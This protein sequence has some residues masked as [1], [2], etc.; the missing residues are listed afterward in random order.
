[1][2]FETDRGDPAAD[3]AVR[4]HSVWRVNAD[5][6][7]ARSLIASSGSD[8]HPTLSSDGGRVAYLHT[9]TPDDVESWQ[10]VVSQVDGSNARVLVEG[11]RRTY[12]PA[13]SP[14]DMAIVIPLSEDG[15]VDLWRIDL[16][17]GERQ[18]L[19]DTPEPEYDPD[20]SSTGLVFRRDVDE[21]NAEIFTSDADGSNARRITEHP[22]YDS[23]PRWSTDGSLILFTR[24]FGPGNH[25]VCVMGSDGSSV[26][27]L[28]N[29]PGND[30]DAMWLSTDESIVFVSD[31]D[32][33]S[34]IYTMRSDGSDQQRLM[35]STS[36]DGTP[37][38]R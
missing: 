23:D 36:R 33:G 18:Q 2:V 6:S 11:V 16:A 12:R 37:D 5:G 1:V 24:N 29:A 32:G 8:G 25:E 20:W 4:R 19:T 22:G 27:N 21:D 34:Q 13:W 26:V 31:R 14:D 10:L 28:T 30:Q 35:E 7:D 9:D 3:P 17:N 15:Q 38:G